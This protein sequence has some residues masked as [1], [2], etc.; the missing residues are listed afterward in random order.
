MCLFTKISILSV[1]YAL[2]LTLQ[3]AGAQTILDPKDAVVDTTAHRKQ[4][5]FGQIGKWER[6]KKLTWNSDSYK[7]Y[8]YKG[9]QFRLKFP[10][11]YNP[12]ITDGKKYPVYV[13]FHGLGEKGDIY[14]NDYQLYNGGLIF[15]NAV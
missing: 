6:T 7:A 15:S 10:K 11:T 9:R 12:A 8:I 14:D 2:T 5:V 3:N 13:F 1:C 4:P